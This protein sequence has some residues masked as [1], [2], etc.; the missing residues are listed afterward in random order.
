MSESFGRHTESGTQVA[1][2]QVAVHIRQASHLA[3]G[4]VS[5][6]TV[7]HGYGEIV[8]SFGSCGKRHHAFGAR[9]SEQAA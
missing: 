9:Q 5:K 4:G 2:G 1:R 8:H 3:E 6:L 7:V